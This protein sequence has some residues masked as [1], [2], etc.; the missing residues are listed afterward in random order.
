MDCQR[1]WH[2]SMGE[3]NL[4]VFVPLSPSRLLPDL[5][6]VG[7]ISSLLAKSFTRLPT[8][9]QSNYSMANDLSDIIIILSEKTFRTLG[10]DQLDESRWVSSDY[11]GYSL[12]VDPARHEM[13]QQRHVHIAHDRHIGAKKKQVAWNADRTRHDRQNFNTSFKSMSTAKTTARKALG[14]PL[15]VILESMTPKEQLSLLVDEAFD[16]VLDESIA[17]PSSVVDAICFRLRES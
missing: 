11:P 16:E 15:D 5:T 3:G 7:M 1:G 10:L 12:R 9:E 8:R 14:L 2:G 6:T 13:R 4:G 17:P